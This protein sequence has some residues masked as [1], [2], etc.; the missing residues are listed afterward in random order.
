M[1]P[2]LKRRS[3]LVKGPRTVSSGIFRFLWVLMI[4]LGFLTGIRF[5]HCYRAMPPAIFWPPG[6]VPKLRKAVGNF[7]CGLLPGIGVVFLSPSGKPLTFP[8][9]TSSDK[10]F[11]FGR[12]CVRPGMWMDG[13]CQ[14]AAA[15][16][17]FWSFPC[18]ALGVKP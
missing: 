3:G 15:L 9:W 14:S 18:L 1:A 5:L 10:G 6:D 8:S 13:R 11:K 17:F 16:F 12:L 4:W 7:F 2:F